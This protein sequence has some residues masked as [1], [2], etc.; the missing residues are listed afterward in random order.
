MEHGEEETLSEEEMEELSEEGRELAK[1]EEFSRLSET[2]EDDFV[3]KSK[4]LHPFAKKAKQ[5][6]PIIEK[7]MAKPFFFTNQ[8]SFCRNR[9][10]R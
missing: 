4:R 6:A 9:L 2:L 8:S 7:K 10:Y 1:E 3:T 5:K